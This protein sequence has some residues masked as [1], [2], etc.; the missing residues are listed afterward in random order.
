MTAEQLVT[1]QSLQR[2][3]NFGTIETLHI[4]QTFINPFGEEWRIEEIIRGRWAS[5]TLNCTYIGGNPI[6]EDMREFVR[7][8]KMEM[9][10]DSIADG[11]AQDRIRKAL[12]EGY[13]AELPQS[14]H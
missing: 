6:R 7:D 1:G 5:P 13:T 9:Y 11:L 10:A 14:K 8:G 4:G 3:T 12:Q 2:R